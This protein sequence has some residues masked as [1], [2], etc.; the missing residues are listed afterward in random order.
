MG[1]AEWQSVCRPA[2][3][4]VGVIETFVFL[5]VAQRQPEA[6][7]RPDG[8]VIPPTMSGLNSEI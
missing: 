2:A 5:L 8:A 7:C 3:W 1:E 6:S 4:V